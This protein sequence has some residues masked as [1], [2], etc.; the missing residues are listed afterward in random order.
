MT[1]LVQGHDCLLLDLDGTLFRGDRQIDHAAQVLTDSPIA[2]LFTTN[3]ASRSAEGT[4][5]HLRDVGLGDAA[6][7]NVVTSAQS[8]ARM[9]AIEV[10]AGSRILVVGTDSLAD[11]LAEVGLEPVRR[12][13][14]QLDAVVQGGSQQLC[15]T[16]LAEAGLAIRNGVGW[17]ATNLDPTLPSERGLVPDNGALVDALTTATNGAKPQLA[18]KPS[19]WFADA[20]RDRGEFDAPLVIGDRVDTD[21]AGANAAGLSNLMVLT[22]SHSVHEAVHAGAAERPTHIGQDVG[23]L[24]RKADDLA[25]VPQSAWGA[26]IDDGSVTVVSRDE[27]QAADELSIVRAVASAVWSLDP[28]E[29]A[30]AIKAGDDTARVALQRWGLA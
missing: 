13:E 2:K 16:D 1:T 11:D 21:I 7:D 17:V 29:G 27:D 9:L 23:A 24:H 14:G 30:V 15:W 12:C 18:G 22:G 10:P 4:A 6:A 3:N 26:E 25:V 5:A 19:P 28:D 20:A 8:A